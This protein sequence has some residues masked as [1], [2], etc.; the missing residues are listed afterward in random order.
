MSKKDPKL[1]KLFP[2]D[3]ASD[4]QISAGM[5]RTIYGKVY[6]YL[7]D[8]KIRKTGDVEAVPSSIMSVKELQK[9]AKK[10]LG[11]ELSKRQI[12]EINAGQTSDD[13]GFKSKRAT[14]PELKRR[15]ESTTKMLEKKRGQAKEILEAKDKEVRESATSL[16]E[17]RG[18]LEEV[19]GELKEAKPEDRELIK[20]RK[21]AIKYGIRKQE[22]SLSKMVVGGDDF[23]ERRVLTDEERGITAVNPEERERQRNYAK[24]VELEQRQRLIEQSE[25]DYKDSMGQV[26]VMSIDNLAQEVGNL[27][28]RIAKRS[29][30]S[31]GRISQ[32][33][34]NLAAAQQFQ[35]PAVAAQGVNVQGQ[36]QG[37]P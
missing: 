4:S 5:A 18:L 34:A 13:K 36:I 12:D 14:T 20:V 16:A 22:K 1:A 29:G 28:K 2:A 6:R 33:Q 26:R 8:E 17:L 11:F 32:T 31:V 37:A 10:G 27:Q 21:G 9:L 25:F 7:R 30:I 35:G 15:L 24:Q 23:D 3:L 19:R